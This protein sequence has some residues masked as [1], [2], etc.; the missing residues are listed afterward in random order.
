MIKTNIIESINSKLK[1]TIVPP[2]IID[3]ED[4]CSKMIAT[5]EEF[6][7]GDLIDKVPT[8]KQLNS[9]KRKPISEDTI[10]KMFED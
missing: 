10:L 9:I 2:D 8:L 7:N 6:L 4:C 1:F 3:D 5:D